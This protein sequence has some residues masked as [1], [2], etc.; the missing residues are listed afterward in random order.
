MFKHVLWVILFLSLPA[1]ASKTVTTA[2]PSKK[3]EEVKAA[4]AKEAAYD[5][6]MAAEAAVEQATK[7]LQDFRGTPMPVIEAQQQLYQV[8]LAAKEE[9]LERAQFDYQQALK[10]YQE[11]K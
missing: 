5:T 1:I 7:A 4:N 2:A 3:A 10:A 11:V 9:A 6:V 8:T